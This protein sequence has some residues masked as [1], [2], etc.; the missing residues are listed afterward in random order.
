MISV[1]GLSYEEPCD[2][3]LINLVHSLLFTLSVCPD[4][5]SMTRGIERLQECRVVVEIK[6]WLCSEWFSADA[7]V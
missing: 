7:A 2:F 6:R 5:C 1:R 4:V 3:L